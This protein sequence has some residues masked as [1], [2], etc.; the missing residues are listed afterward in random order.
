MGRKEQLEIIYDYLRSKGIV[1]TKKEFAQKLEMN[2]SSI[3]NAF[4]GNE[5]CLTESLFVS[6]IGSTF[7][8]IF[9]KEWLKTGTGN[10]LKSDGISVTIGE[11]VNNGS[12]T[13]KVVGL[14]LED[15]DSMK[16]MIILLQTK[17]AEQ[18]AYINQ[19]LEIINNLSKNK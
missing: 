15:T 12:G 8:D 10:M 5:K 19:L 6:R 16:N 1:H 11:M 17:C 3:S 4:S 2:Y 13:Q 7:S 18:D 9:S 14:N